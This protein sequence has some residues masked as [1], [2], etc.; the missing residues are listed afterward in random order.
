MALTVKITDILVK[1]SGERFQG[2]MHTVSA[3]L[4][5]KDIDVI[6]FE[7]TFSENH[8]DIYAIADTMEKIRVKM[9]E[10]KKRLE[11]ELALKIEAEKE[12][13]AML[14]KIQEVK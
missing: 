4:I 1:S 6:I 9:D 7:K 14:T 2:K 5:L 13:P 12:V 3:K 8:K 10:A 11:A